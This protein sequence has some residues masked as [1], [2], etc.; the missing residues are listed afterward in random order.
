MTYSNDN[1]SGALLTSVINK[2]YKNDFDV[3][4]DVMT[5]EKFSTDYDEKNPVSVC[6]KLYQ[7]GARHGWNPLTV[8]YAVKGDNEYF[9][10]KKGKVVITEKGR[11]IFTPDDFGKHRI[12]LLNKP[13]NEVAKYLESFFGDELN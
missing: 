13:K 8:L 9:S 5:F 11:T 4:L 12:V 6:Y 10:S 2:Y 1:Q 7:N 3:G